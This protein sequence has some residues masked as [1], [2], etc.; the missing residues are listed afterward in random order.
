[1]MNIKAPSAEQQKLIVAY[2]Q[3]H[4]L[5]SIEP[6]ALPSP[7]SKGAVLFAATC[8]QCHALPDPRQHT[9]QEWPQVVALMRKNMVVMGKTVPDATTLQMI[10]E[11]L[12]DASRAKP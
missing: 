8:T 12:E 7:R 4:S 6:G 9:A 2:W 11:F 10:T 5:K 1:M 3:K